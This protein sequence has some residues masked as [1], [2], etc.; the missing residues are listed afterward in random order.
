M[1]SKWARPNR[2]ALTTMANGAGTRPSRARRSRPLKNNSSTN[3]APTAR[4]MTRTT[5]E[6]EVWAAAVSLWAGWP[7][8]CV[9]VR[10]AFSKGRY[11]SGTS[12]Y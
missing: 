3:G 6:T 2:R 9:R 11:S 7:S 12:P 8:W 1:A 4:K 10:S 5:T